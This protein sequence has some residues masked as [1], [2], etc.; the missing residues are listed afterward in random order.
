[1]MLAFGCKHVFTLKTFSQLEEPDLLQRVLLYCQSTT[2]LLMKELQ[3]LAN[4]N[5][6]TKAGFLISSVWR[7]CLSGVLC[8]IGRTFCVAVVAVSNMV[9][10]LYN[11]HLYDQAFTI[12]E[13]LCKDLCQ[14]HAVSL[15]VDRVSV[16]D[17]T[18]QC[19]LNHF[20]ETCCYLNL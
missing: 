8:F 13:I 3:K 18:P 4:E 19:W 14:K 1:M 9:C 6:F 20:A 15:S 2:G 12:V 5:L 16:K 17:I 11:R 7:F 10:G